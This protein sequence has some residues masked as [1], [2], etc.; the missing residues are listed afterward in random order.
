MGIGLAALPAP[1][2][3]TDFNLSISNNDQ[4][5]PNCKLYTFFY[6]WHTNQAQFIMWFECDSECGMQ[7]YSDDEQQYRIEIG[8]KTIRT[9]RR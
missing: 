4:K 8:Q 9:Q 3:V 5:V 7:E 1:Q 6:R 2:V